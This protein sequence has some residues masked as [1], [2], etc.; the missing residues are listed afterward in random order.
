[1]KKKYLFILVI[2]LGYS[3]T[4]SVITSNARGSAA[5][6]SY[7]E[8]GSSTITTVISTDTDNSSVSPTWTA[9]DIATNVV[10]AYGVYAADMD[11]DGDIDILSASHLDDTIAWYENNGASDPS[12]S[13]SVITTSADGALS[14]YAADM[15]GDGDMDIISGSY[16]DNTVAWYEN[17]GASDPSWSKSVITT[18]ADGLKS[19]YAADMDG[20]GDMDIISASFFD[21]TI[22]WY[23]NNGTSDPIWTAQDIAISA[24]GARSAYA[25]DMDGDGDMDIVSASSKDYTIAWYENNGASDPSW[26]A[27]D[28]TTSASEAIWIYAADMDGDGDMDIVSASRNDDTIAWYENNG[29]SDPS[30]SKSVITTSADLVYCVYAMDIDGDGDM[31]IISASHL[32]DTI[33]WYENNG[34]SDPSWS[35]SVITTSAD[36]AYGVYAADMDGDGDLDII[37]AS[38]GDSTIAWYEQGKGYSPTDITLSSNSINENESSGTIIGTLSST[39]IDSGDS[40]IY[41]LVNGTGSMNNSSFSISDASLQTSTTFDYETKSSYNIRIRTTDSEGLA[42]EKAFT[43]AITDVDEIQPV[44]LISSNFSSHTNIDTIPVTVT[45]SEPV[46]GFDNSDVLIENALMISFEGEDSIYAMDIIPTNLED[47]KISIPMQA[48]QDATGNLNE[49][50]F[51]IISYSELGID[52]ILIP[53]EFGIENIFPNPF[54]PVIR[55]VFGLPEMTSFKL[56]VY[57]ISG[58][59]VAMLFN[60]SKMPGYHSIEWNAS[61]LSSGVYFVHMMSDEITHTQKLFLIK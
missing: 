56:T 45:F 17:N 20:D 52:K 39:D 4:A 22:A 23:E 30:W 15:D 33:A 44:P 38:S 43:I 34:A 28:I 29:A 57:N 55:I 40:H 41:T 16:S 11:G 50:A 49:G 58:R 53:S 42:C 5:S 26:T 8:N 13:K 61:D 51:F 12:W 54:N 37:S 35:K 2:S 18:S 24:N 21:N 19:I 10:G 3:Q 59:Q 7:A 6:I 9:R 60:G 36:G 14:V 47:I 1:M 27:Q 48:C 25:A 31:D 46:F 32:D